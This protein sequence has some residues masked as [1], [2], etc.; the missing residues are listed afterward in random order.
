MSDLDEDLDERVVKAVEEI[1]RGN[2][3]ESVAAWQQLPA[4]IE[5]PNFASIDVCRVKE[6]VQQE[7][8]L[9]R[10]CQRLKKGLLYG[11]YV[12]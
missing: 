9:I 3:Q 7:S 8:R 4:S 11:T 6:A 2:P 1:T 10:S 5:C 12:R